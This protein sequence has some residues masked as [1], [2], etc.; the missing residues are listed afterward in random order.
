MPALSGRRKSTERDVIQTFARRIKEIAS[1]PPTDRGH[2]L[3][4]L[5]KEALAAAATCQKPAAAQL[6]DLAKMA[7]PAD[8]AALRRE[9]EDALL[10]LDEPHLA[11]NSRSSRGDFHCKL[12][13]Y[14]NDLG[15]V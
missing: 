10:S 1:A 8:E 5:A 13:P 3:R 15:E 6:L 4:G 12:Y 11:A 2:R 14:T 9:I 7:C